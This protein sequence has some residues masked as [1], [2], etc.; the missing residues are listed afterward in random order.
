MRGTCLA[1]SF[2]GMNRQPSVPGH[3]QAGVAALLHFLQQAGRLSAA[4][5]RRIQRA[6]AQPNQS[7]PDLLERERIIAQ[8]ELAILL[9]ESLQLPLLRRLRDAI[10][11][12]E[13]PASQT[14]TRVAV[15]MLLEDALVKLDE[16]AT[17][18]LPSA[19][20][21]SAPDP[22]ANTSPRAASRSFR[23]LVVDDD[24]DLRRI[25][26]GTLERSDL[27]LTVITAQDA[28]EALALLQL[29]HP[30]VVILDVAMPG[31]DGFELC[32]RVRHDAHTKQ[33][34]I[35]ILTAMGALENAS[36]A[37]A[38][39]ADEFMVKPVRRE[40]LIGCVRRLIE[41]AYPVADAV[42]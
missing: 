8:K 39:G 6:A 26:R 11:A 23:A 16:G 36:K 41:R 38:A 10:S 28:N 3:S 1:V 15:S 31:I 27:G 14:A 7:V 21:A 35:V 2:L 13:S 42:A 40:D 29:E 22:V 30:D 34:P 20:V 25:V 24:P 32:R 33:M 17:P 19:A 4:D 5:G 37:R 9:G 12:P 18:A